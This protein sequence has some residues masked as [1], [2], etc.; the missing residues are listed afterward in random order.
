M[1]SDDTWTTIFSER[2]SLAEDLSGLA[3]EQWATPSLCPQWTVRDAVAHM[4]ASA[5][6]T[7][8]SFFPRLIGNGFSLSRL[9][10]KD[11]ARERGSSA[12][13]TL[14][15]FRAIETSKKRPPGPLDTM[16]GETILHAE[17][18]RRPLGLRHVYPQ[19]ALEQVAN[20]YKGS[21][22][23]IGTKRRID[24]VRLSASDAAWSWGDGP[25]A[26]GAMLSIVL[27]MTG[28][29]AAL[30]DLSGEGVSVLEQRP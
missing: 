4:T 3:D 21:N 23:I 9:Q 26:E 5:K 18:V 1:N 27:A 8:A 28:R 30:A 7:P 6:I 11:I 19:P 15:G 22:L 25:V 2:K 29:K 24:G 13:D 17:D 20:F 14:D 16:L 10:T 12:R